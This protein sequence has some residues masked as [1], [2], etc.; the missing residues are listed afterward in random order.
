MRAFPRLSVIGGLPFLRFRFLVTFYFSS[1]S[2]LQE[3]LFP[4][5]SH[6]PGGK[7]TL[8]ETPFNFPFL[9]RT[10]RESSRHLVSNVIFFTRET[11]NFPVLLFFRPSRRNCRGSRVTAINFPPGR[12]A[13][14]N[15]ATARTSFSTTRTSP[16]LQAKLNLYYN[17]ILSSPGKTGKLVSLELARKIYIRD[18]PPMSSVSSRI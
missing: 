14:I 2:L 5:L 6:S 9:S 3:S 1:V 7:H 4:L 18:V 16:I 12:S 10:Q 11:S 13:T 17:E 8:A 15:R